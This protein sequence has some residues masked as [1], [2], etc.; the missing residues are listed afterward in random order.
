MPAPSWL[1]GDFPAGEVLFSGMLAGVERALRGKEEGSCLWGE[2]DGRVRMEREQ[3]IM[4][5]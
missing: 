1:P 5:L 4:S 3:I 2:G